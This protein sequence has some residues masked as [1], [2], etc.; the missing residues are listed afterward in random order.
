MR[1]PTRRRAHILFATCLSIPYIL[2]SQPLSG[3]EQ[4]ETIVITAAA[5]TEPPTPGTTVIS[6]NDARRSGAGTV[7]E[8]IAAV[9]GI[10]LQ[11]TGSSYEPVLVRVRGSTSEQVLV[12]RD[13]MP[14]SN[15]YSGIVDLSRISLDRVERIE[16]VRGPVNALYGGGAA[17]AINII[18][19]EEPA[20]ATTEL[21]SGEGRYSFGS[22]GEH[23]AG[24][25][26]T[27]AGGALTLGVTAGG[28]VAANSYEYERAGAS[29]PRENAGGRD[30]ALSVTLDNRDRGSFL[31]GETRLTAE[32]S[33]RGAPGSIEFP[34]TTATVEDQRLA[35]A[36]GVDMAPQEGMSLR[37][38]GDIQRLE[39]SFRDD[40]Y[41]LGALRSETELRT[42][43]GDLAG[44]IA[45]GHL[46]AGVTL[47][48]RYSAIEDRELGEVGRPTVA[49]APHIAIGNRLRV[50]GTGRLEYVTEDF[51][52]SGRG[53]I[54]FA[55]GEDLRFG[56]IGAAGYRLPTFLELFQPAGAFVSGN[57]DL[58]P[59]RST[60]IEAEITVGRTAS[61][62]LRAS[63]YLVRYR[64]LIQW[65][66]GPDG[67]WSARNTGT[68]RIRGLEIEGRFDLPI[69]I[70]LWTAGIEG[71][72]EVLDAVDTNEGVTRDKILPYRARART[73]SGV[74]LSHPFGHS[75]RIE[76]EYVG[77]RPVNA[78]NTV[79][80]DP[81]LAIDATARA[82]LPVG[83]VEEWFFVLGINNLVDEPYVATRYYPNPGREVTIGTEVRW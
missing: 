50:E 63:V 51:L 37:L 43:G 82:R 1:E 11:A 73:G 61:R 48:G 30:G 31:E 55:P 20:P 41:P 54:A 70:G 75:F 46:E 19:T 25:G 47:A 8:A 60:S 80:L 64:E 12:L 27:H 71:R 9:P 22:F 72:L 36:L 6:A 3:Q 38:A 21:W 76:T 33:R 65:V 24:A 39:R 23:R 18:T 66:A 68:A 74:V 81:Y 26:V 28:V 7:A 69:P 16:I 15:S 10:S 13:G 83:G 57:P 42:V 35:L 44:T 67:R 53:T 14:L 59:E 79:W 5:P 2:S 52:P 58:A 78:Q 4:T 49:V 77:A 40:E 29:R 17:G 45:N 34:T 62:E 56:I 32:G